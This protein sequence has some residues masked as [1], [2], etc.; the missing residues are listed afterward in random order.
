MALL[1]ALVTFLTLLLVT[2][3][4]GD[5]VFRAAAVIAFLGHVF[6]S[7][8]MVPEVPYGWD[9]STFHQTA[10]TLLAG[11]FPM[12]SSTVASFGTIQALLY[13]FLPSRPET[14]GTFNALCA[15]LVFIPIRYLCKRL[16]P[17][18][19]SDHYG[20]MVLVLFLPLPFFIQSIPMR[21][22]F[23]ILLFFSLLALALHALL[24]RQR[25]FAVT[26]LPLWG[27]V[28]LLRPELALIAFLGVLTAAITEVFRVTNTNLSIPKLG[29]VLGAV[30]AVGFGLFAELLY[31]FEAV[32]DELAHRAHGGAVYLDG[33]QYTSW[34]DFLLALPGRAIYFQFA[35][36]PLHVESIFHLLAFSATPIVIILFI[37]AARS[38]YECET[39][40]TVAVLLVVVYLAGIAG[41]GAIN[42]N[43]GTNVRH[44]IVFDFL[45]VLMAAPVIK[46]WRLLVRDWLGVVP[47]ERGEHDEHERET[48]KLDRGVQIR[49][50]DSD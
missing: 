29:V 48:E 1:A 36:F 17:S 16:Y 27:M 32:N 19:N 5:R 31:P 10:L 8:V 25:L 26:V 12:E 47:G 20:V 21:D 6:V 3:L 34:F 15:V 28:F 14:V 49:S 33:M 37:S 24:T 44:R 42:S 9:I 41:Y 38:L 13:V 22:A 46:R 43:F 45:L 35:P 11:Q 50:Q 23:T 30:G 40:E 2:K 7:F 4:Y 39:D 18:S